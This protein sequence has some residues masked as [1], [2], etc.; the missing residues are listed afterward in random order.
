MKLMEGYEYTTLLY[1]IIEIA[2]IYAFGFSNSVE[3]NDQPDRANS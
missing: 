1:V 2:P 3:R